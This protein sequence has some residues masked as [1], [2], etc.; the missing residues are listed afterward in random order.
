MIKLLTGKNALITGASRGIGRGI[1]LELAQQGANV[2]FTFLSSPDK[3]AELEKELQTLGVKAKGY[4]SD[5]SE[6]KAADELINNI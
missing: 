1:A 4:Q 6:F 2:A 3:A 5:A